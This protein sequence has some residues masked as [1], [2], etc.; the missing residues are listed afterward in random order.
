VEHALVGVHVNRDAV[1]TQAV[2]VQSP[3][4]VENVAIGQQHACGRETGQGLGEQGRCVWVG[5]VI[6][7]L[8]V[9]LPVPRHHLGCQPEALRVAFARLYASIRVRFARDD[10][11]PERMKPDPYRVRQAVSILQAD[12]SECTLIGVTT[13]DVM[14]GHL[15]GVAV[16]GYANKPGK[17]RAL[18]EVQAAAITTD[19]VSTTTALRTR[20]GKLLIA[21]PSHCRAPNGWS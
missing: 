5:R 4:V 19:L 18:A 20:N 9:L 1:L 12:N 16:I 10:D 14:A 6:V 7:A 17:A 15:A 21:A 8:Q 13:G 3:L 2:G 11:D